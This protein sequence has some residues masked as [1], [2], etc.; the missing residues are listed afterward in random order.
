MDKVFDANNNEQVKEMAYAFGME[1]DKV[2]ECVSCADKL[3]HYF[4]QSKE[5]EK[6]MIGQMYFEWQS[7]LNKAFNILDDFSNKYN[8][9]L[10]FNKL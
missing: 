3:E 6:S 5:N 7:A 1:I 10:M 9:Y 4:L 8:M 2:L